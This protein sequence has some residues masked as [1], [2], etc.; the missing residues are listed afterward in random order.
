MGRNLHS[1]IRI[2]GDLVAKTPVHSGGLRDSVFTDLPLAV[3]GKDEVYFPGSAIAGPLRAWWRGAC[4]DL[5]EAVW[6]R[7]EGQGGNNGGWAS[8]LF[9][10]DAP[11]IKAIDR[12]LAQH[13]A[14]DRWS[15]TAAFK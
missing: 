8:I 13:V 5:E 4:S 15:G 7:V 11:L 10:H 2:E 9:V 14:I 1:V 12:D 6:G 3:N